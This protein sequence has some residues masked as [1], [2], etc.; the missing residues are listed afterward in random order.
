MNHDLFLQEAF[1]RYKGFLYLKKKN[2]EQFIS[3]F[4]VPTYDIDLMWHSHILHPVNYC[5]DTTRAIGKILEHVEDADRTEGKRLDKG[6]SDTSKQ[7][8]DTF[9]IRYSKAG[10]MFR[11]LPP[12][13]VTTSPYKPNGARNRV[14]SFAPSPDID[15]LFTPIPKKTMV[16]VNLK[17][18]SWIFFD[19]SVTF[20]AFDVRFTMQVC[21]EIID[22]RNLPDGLAEDDN[23]SVF[24]SKEK[25]DAFFTSKRRLSIKSL[26][27]RKQIAT[28]QCESIGKFLIELSYHSKKP[29]KLHLSK[30]DRP[31]GSF[32]VPLSDYLPPVSKLSDE[33][34]FELG[35]TSTRVNSKALSL[36]VALS[37]TIPTAAPNVLLMVLPSKPASRKFCFFPFQDRTL[38]SRSLTKVEDVSG[39]QIISLQMRYTITHTLLSISIF[40]M[41]FERCS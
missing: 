3:Q 40:R 36:R 19:V 20:S 5:N 39:T 4:N 32:L 31:L 37:F 38:N 7:W 15:Q 29:P 28:F 22:V 41:S 12:K 35:M 33:K 26:S 17:F 16:E 10:A 25:S 1:S 14:V 23:I 8:E 24:V 27:G 30:A 2:E 11:G 21:I 18:V 13:P 6:F 34:W 9:G